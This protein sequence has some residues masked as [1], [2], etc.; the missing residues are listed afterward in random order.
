M[1][2]DEEFP[3][4]VRVTCPAHDRAQKPERVNRDEPPCELK[5]GGEPTV[6]P[7]LL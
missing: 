2:R 4:Y 3:E 7:P 1:E 5:E 6:N